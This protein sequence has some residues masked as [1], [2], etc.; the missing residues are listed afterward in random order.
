MPNAGSYPG[1]AL[2]NAQPSFA[3]MA[4]TPGGEALWGARAI[5]FLIDSCFVAAVM[6]VL[7][8]VFTLV[9]SLVAGAGAVASGMDQSGAAAGMF[10]SQ[11]CAMLAIFPV[12]ALSVGAYN[13]CYLVSKPG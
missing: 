1:G 13:R 2:P 5:G 4:I 8:I 7:G 6:V 12:A 3:G 10:L 9:S 11:Y